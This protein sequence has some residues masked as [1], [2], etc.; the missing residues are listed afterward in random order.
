MGQLKQATFKRDENP[1]FQR[2][3]TNL[4]NIKTCT[5]IGTNYEIE[6][7]KEGKKTYLQS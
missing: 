2:L 5:N 4:T 6:R 3:S 7:K 1:Y